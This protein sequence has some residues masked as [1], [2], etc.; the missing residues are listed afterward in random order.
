MLRLLR[1]TALG[2][3]S[4]VL[5]YAALALVL[6]L[7]PRNRDFRE[8][9]DGIEIW[10]TTNRVHAA[11]V[12]PRRTD[13]IDWGDI[14]P[15]ADTLMGTPQPGVEW[16][17][18]GWGARTFF[19]QTPRWSDL[20]LGAVLTALSG[21]GGAA[22]HVAHTWVP[23]DGRRIRLS[24]AAYTRLVSSI[25]AS[26]QMENGQARQIPEA[27]YGYGDAFYEAHGSY[28]PIFTCN[29]WVRD[30]LAWAGV[31]VPVWAPFDQ[32]LFWQLRN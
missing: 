23:R 25:R 12:L 20:S 1:R 11:L 15:P 22:L 30:A 32:A 19:L 6:G 29:Q 16:V 14:F 21:Q 24:V 9:D 13:V 27:R 31:R 3:L 17:S 7:V 28:S 4:V 8:S 26:V 18:I 5:L 10:L 2:L